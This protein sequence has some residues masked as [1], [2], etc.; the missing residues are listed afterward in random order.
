MP[1]D[2]PATMTYLIT[3]AGRRWPV[4]TTFRTGRDAFGWDQCQART[5]DAICRHTV[6]TALAQLRNAAVRAAITGAMALPAA[7]PARETA[8]ATSDERPAAAADL[9][10]YCGDAPLPSSAGQPCPPDIVPIR[11]S[12]AET[13]RIELLARNWKSGILTAARLAFHLSW[14]AWRRRHQARARWHHYA[15]RLEALAT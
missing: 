11:L 5:W 3:I 2:R 10:F 8:A 7:R 6:L 15:T 1:E 14:S 9:Q 12:A 4:E 13:A